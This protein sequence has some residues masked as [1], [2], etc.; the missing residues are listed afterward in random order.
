MKQAGMIMA[1][2]LAGVLGCSRAPDTP[3]PEGKQIDFADLM[4]QSSGPGTHY[5]YEK[6]HEDTPFTGTAVRSYEDGR[7]AVTEFKNGKGNGLSTLW[8]ANGNKAMEV[9]LV[10]DKPHGILTKWDEKGNELSRAEYV[11]GKEIAQPE[12]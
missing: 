2:A 10:D 7:R 1:I 8:Q 11:N 4:Q 12:N 9:T 6:G 5:V 3:V